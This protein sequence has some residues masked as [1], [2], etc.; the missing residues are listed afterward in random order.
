VAYVV[1]G[2]LGAELRDALGQR[3]RRKVDVAD[4]R[5]EVYER[6]AV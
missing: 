5:I 1:A 3:I 4:P 6:T 2:D